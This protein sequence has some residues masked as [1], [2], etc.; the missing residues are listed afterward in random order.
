MTQMDI[1][2]L[3]RAI[4]TALFEFRNPVALASLLYHQELC[5]CFGKLVLS[6][7]DT[8][9][10]RRELR[11]LANAGYV[12]EIAGFDDWYKLA[13]GLRLTMAQSGLDRKDPVLFGPSA[14]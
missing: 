10:I 8:L 9:L 6:P 3:R 5:A 14:L 1:F 12:S 4:L 11:E 7:G 13:A 2:A